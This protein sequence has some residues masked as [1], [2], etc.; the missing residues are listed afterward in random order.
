MKP[1]HLTILFYVL[2]ITNAEL[3]DKPFEQQPV[4]PVNKP[5]EAPGIP[6]LPLPVNVPGFHRQHRKHSP[7]GAPW[8]RLAPAQP[9]DYGPLVTAAHAPSS[10]SLSKPSMKKNGLVPPSAG[11]APP[12]SSPSTLPTGLA[13]PPLSPHTSSKNLSS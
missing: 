3:P 4:S 7:H 9:P 12:Q 5:V 2:C 11:L 6:D 8:L 1:K 13:Q 10:S